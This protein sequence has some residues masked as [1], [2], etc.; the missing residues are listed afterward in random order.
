MM[1]PTAFACGTSLL[2][3]LL[4]VGLA[5]AGPPASPNFSYSVAPLYHF[6]SGLEDGGTVGFAGV[7]TSLGGSRKLGGFPGYA[8]VFRL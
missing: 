3:L 2:S 5:A 8:S 1:P 7:F 4:A 6:D